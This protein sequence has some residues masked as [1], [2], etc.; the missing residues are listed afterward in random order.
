VFDE[1]YI[2]FHFNIILNTKG[3][4]LLKKI[5]RTML[6][7]S[8]VFIRTSLSCILYKYFVRILQQFMHGRTHFFQHTFLGCSIISVLN[9]THEL[10]TVS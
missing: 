1:V 2:L 10:T 5:D 4:P 3:C 9:I 7:I 6:A 8:E